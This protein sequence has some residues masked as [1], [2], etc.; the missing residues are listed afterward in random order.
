MLSYEWH[1][2]GTKKDDATAKTIQIGNTRTASEEYE[3][4]VKTATKTSV[5]SAIKNV[6]FLCKYFVLFKVLDLVHFSLW[7]IFLCLTCK[8]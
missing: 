1:I 6:L 3:C 5:K 8:K 2:N 4:A 7:S